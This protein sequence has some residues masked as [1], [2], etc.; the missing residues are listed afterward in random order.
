MAD[1]LDR[2]LD[3]LAADRS[4]L[5]RLHDPAAQLALVEGLA[6]AVV[7]DDLRHDELGGLEGRE[8]LAA[9]QAFAAAPDLVTLAGEARVRHLGVVV[10]A[11]RAMHG[12]GLRRIHA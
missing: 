2:G 9:G 11:E 1:A 5:E 8:P 10:V 4:L 7:L 3:R 6:R 12:R